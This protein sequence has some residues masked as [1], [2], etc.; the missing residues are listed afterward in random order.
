MDSYKISN[1]L[2]IHACTAYCKYSKGGPSN[3][4]QKGYQY[5]TSCFRAKGR[6]KVPVHMY[7]GTKDSYWYMW[8]CSEEYGFRMH[9]VSISSIDLHTIMWTPFGSDVAH[10]EGCGLYFCCGPL[11]GK[12][13]RTS[14]AYVDTIS[15][16]VGFGRADP[17][18]ALTRSEYTRLIIR[19][20]ERGRAYIHACTTW[21]IFAT[22]CAP[23]TTGRVN[24]TGRRAPSFP[25]RAASCGGSILWYL[26]RS[27]LRGQ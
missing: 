17:K 27:A 26:T 10:P 9:F 12:P 1:T 6:P 25:R 11:K 22:C 7:V 19:L 20:L 8:H 24:A 13:S 18:R 21:Q 4:L 3:L 14:V 5:T 2:N 23:P 15:P 16:V